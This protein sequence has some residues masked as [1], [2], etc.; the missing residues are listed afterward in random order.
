MKFR[1]Y[2]LL[3]AV[4]GVVGGHVKNLTFGRR[5]RYNDAGWR[6]QGGFYC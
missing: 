6:V 3:K 5:G 1:P 2:G 4:S